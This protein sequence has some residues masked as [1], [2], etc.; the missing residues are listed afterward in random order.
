MTA[1]PCAWRD[2]TAPATGR[3]TCRRHLARTYAAGHRAATAMHPDDVLARLTAPAPTPGRTPTVNRLADLE[4]LLDGGVTP[5]LAAARV[6]WARDTAL[7][8]AHR[9]G[10]ADLADKFIRRSPARITWGAVA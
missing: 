10:R 8:L 4:W 5:D 1:R 2:C 6:D 7:A 9:H 3:G